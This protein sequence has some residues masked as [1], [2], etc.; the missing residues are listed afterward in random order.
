ME[1]NWTKIR[2]KMFAYCNNAFQENS[3]TLTSEEIHEAIGLFYNF[4]NFSV[5][6]GQIKGIGKEML[7]NLQGAC[8]DNIGDLSQLKLIASLEDPFMKKI[9]VLCGL[10]TYNNVS[11]LTQMPLLKIIGLW[12]RR[13]PEF[14][15]T[16]IETYK[17]NSDGS[18]ILGMTILTRNHVH[19][20]PNW[21]DSE[22]TRRLKY[23]ISFYIF[24]VYKL[25]SQLL[26]NKPELAKQD[27]NFFEE[28]P[29]NALLYDY[30][31]YGSSS[32]EIKK[33]YVRTYVEHQLYRTG[34]IEEQALL[35]TMQD[36]SDK[37]L[38]EEAAK[39]ILTELTREEKVKIVK[40]VPKTFSLSDEENTRIH[41]AEENYNLALQ[42]YNTS[43]SDILS[44][45]GLT[46]PVNTIGSLLMDYLSAQYNYDIEE[47]IGD[48][49][50]IER[51]DYKSFIKKLEGIGC[52]VI[53]SGDLYKELL[54]LNRDN[55]ILVRIS[56]GRAFRR[57]SNPD[58]FNEYFRKADRTVWID[59]QILL[60]LLCYNENYSQYDNHLYKTALALFRYS[61]NTQYFHFKVANF[62][63]NE[64]I[65][66]LHQALLLI[67]VVDMPFA[68]KYN[69]SRNVFYQ[70]YRQLSG[71]DSLPEGVDTFA[72]YMEDNFSLNTDDAY[73][74]DFSNIARGVVE[75]KF[76]DFDIKIESVPQQ[77][78]NDISNSEQILKRVSTSEG[79]TPKQG[80]PLSNDALMG[81]SLF[82][83]NEEQK[84]I[85]ITLDSCFEPYRVQYMQ[86]YRRGL[87]F[88]WHLFSPSAFVNH[89][90]FIDFKV[91]VDNFTDDLISIV[92]TD[93]VKD[94]T[95]T[96]IDRINKFLD[97][98]HISKG[99]RKKYIA[100]VEE[101]FQTQEFSYKPETSSQESVS[102]NVI[103]FLDAQ[104]I[105]FS[106]FH[107][108]K[109]NL[110]QFQ[111][112]LVVEERF[113]NYIGFL[114]EF[115]SEHSA[116]REDL[117]LK[118]EV[119]LEEFANSQNKTNE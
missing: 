4:V 116:N 23:V 97:I 34:S 96:V 106:Y 12:S 110:K 20:S 89:M 62:Y 107:D 50:K 33:R 118:V 80:K 49:S 21:D 115:V 9:I 92:E 79:I 95:L 103:R 54:L 18:Y 84:P 74:Q 51:E 6:Y 42:S 39:R 85:F 15:Q 65:Y 28:N 48:S 73:A 57:I 66:Q 63:V 76:D 25:K 83:H 100:W 117:I 99:T 8:V 67:S 68:K 11:D 56:A 105:V 27:V 78:P 45:Y 91:N 1:Y 87:A 55:D 40:H 3:I 44:R 59:T 108:Q 30:I 109:N 72:D 88:N 93:E 10:D 16:N 61:S 2:E 36:F 38:K 82:K 19:Q 52:P 112:M 69:M 101:L 43:M 114:K 60:Y 119:E 75:S 29:E 104:D 7:N 113:K 17:G 47:A 90:D 37:S 94:K 70:H 14:D 111:E 53:Q 24:L 46:V 41:D 102:P 98:P 31:S 86:R 35:N 13:I 58:Q 22:V 5:P 32:V 26:S 81:V 71:T 77:D 64:I